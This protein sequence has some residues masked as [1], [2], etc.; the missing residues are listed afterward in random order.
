MNVDRIIEI[1]HSERTGLT[2]CV[3]HWTANGKT[4]SRTV[5]GR[6]YGYGPDRVVQFEGTEQQVSYRVG[7]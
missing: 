1:S 7:E 4:T 2:E 5:F 3:V 6:C